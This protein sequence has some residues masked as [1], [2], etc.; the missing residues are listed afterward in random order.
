MTF[1]R[2]TMLFGCA[3]LLASAVRAQPYPSR[4]SGMIVPSPPGASVDY[5]ARLAGCVQ[6]YMASIPGMMP[7]IKNGKLKVLG[8]AGI[9]RVNVSPSVPAIAETISGYEFVGTWYG[10]LAQAKVP[11]ARGKEG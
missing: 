5:T 6:T 11:P 3:L 1:R 10:L 4:P 8:V 9:E 7:L 2:W